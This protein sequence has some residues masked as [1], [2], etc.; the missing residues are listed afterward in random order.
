[1]LQQPA[2]LWAFGWLIKA[3]VC[4]T[5]TYGHSNAVPLLL[6]LGVL[7]ALAVS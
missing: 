7:G 6:I 2:D 4:Y 1:M 5:H 3:I